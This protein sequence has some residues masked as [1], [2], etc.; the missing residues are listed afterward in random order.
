[1]EPSLT[2]FAAF[3][4]SARN[5]HERPFLHVTADTAQRY[6]ISP[7]TI[8]YGDAATD[9]ATLRQ[10]YQ[11]AGYGTG[12][13]IG[14]ML[15]NRPSAFLHWFALNAL[16]ASVVPLNA[17]LRSAE[18]TYLLDHSQMCLAVTTPSHLDKLRAAA[19][20]CAIV[21]D[22]APPPPAPSPARHE[23]P[24]STTECALLYTSGT[25]GK[26]K[27]CVLSNDYFLRCGRW[28]T[29]IAQRGGGAYST[30]IISEEME[31]TYARYAEADDW[32]ETPRASSCAQ[33]SRERPRSVVA[34]N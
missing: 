26:P 31:A 17:D 19:N 9:V 2:V 32:G 16:G 8:T 4:A 23:A 13:R 33:R 22:D 14:L 12:H 10:R 11:P 15:E 5:W 21:T 1:M 3:S 20:A 34:G 29:Q 25:T 7:A 30:K 27:G 18:L 24:G 28:Y 6:A